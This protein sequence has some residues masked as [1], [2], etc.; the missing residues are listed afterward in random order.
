MKRTIKNLAVIFMMVIAFCLV[1]MQASAADASV[2][3]FEACNGG[4]MVTNCN[5]AAE[6]SLV[7]P[8]EYNGSKVV[9][10]ADNAFDNCTKLT[11]VTIPEGVKTIG[12]SAF[13]GCK[14]LSEINLPESLTT[15]S[16]YAFFGCDS[17][18]TLVMYP[19]VTTIESYAFYDCA[20]LESIALPESI[21]TIAEGT[22]GECVVLKKVF[23]PKS[24]KVVEATAF[25]NCDAIDNVYY[26]GSMFGWS[27]IEWGEDNSVIMAVNAKNFS[28]VHAHTSVVIKEPTCTDKGRA[29][30]ACECGNVY[31]GDVKALGHSAEAIA[32]VKPTC[33]EAGKTAGEKCSRCEKILTEPGVI[34]ATGHKTVIDP[35]VEPTCDNTGL[36]KG[37]H[38]EFC[39]DTLEKQEVIE[40]I[41]HVFDYESLKKATTKENGKRKGT[42]TLC[43]YEADEV[44]YNVSTFKLSTSK[45]TYNGKTRTPSVTVKDSEG[46]VLIKDRDYTVKYADGRK[47]PGVYN[48]KVT[49]K[50]EYE[51]SKTLKFTIAPGKTSEIKATPS[52]TNAVKLTWKEVTGATGYRVYIYKTTG[53]KTRVKA[54]SVTT[55]SYTLKKNYSGKSLVMGTSYKIAIAAYT[56]TSK[57][58]VIHAENGVA[59]TFKFIPTAPTLTVKSSAKGKAT[60]K[61]SDVAGETGYQLYYS[62]DGKKFTKLD[63]YK[64]WPDAQT[65]SGLKS[66][67]TYYFKVRAYTKVDSKTVHGTFSEVKSVKIK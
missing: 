2:L 46:N 27:G 19:N 32:E 56:K 59:L 47:K 18:K 49:L 64:G 17:I 34:P 1:A 55:N 30:F 21:T 28:H 54:A 22:F 38:C 45:C 61:W 35:A 9:K 48:I 66:S 14:L 5:E 8:A 43:G 13:E 51:G 26:T 41:A 3:S 16:S 37:S 10:I 29:V 62:T 65:K 25:I 36:T 39:G 33:T 58:T 20:S 7:I 53:G 4:V 60:I 50:G 23:V 11:S 57:G 15:I 24:V 52:K 12:E 40:R 44:L 6:G 67:K 31:K 63:S 42:C